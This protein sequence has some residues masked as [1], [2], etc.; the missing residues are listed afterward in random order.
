MSSEPNPAQAVQAALTALYQA[1]DNE[2]RRQ[3][4]LWLRD[5]QKT[6]EAWQVANEL[7]LAQDQPLEGRLFAAQTFRSKV[8][9]DLNQ[10]PSASIPSLRDTLLDALQAYGSGPRVLQTQI[11]LALSALALQMSDWANVIPSIVERFG[12]DP[13]LVPALLEFLTILPE[14]VV[15]NH[16]IP[17][18]E[19]VYHQRV[20]ELLSVHVD[21]VVKVL[22]MYALAKGVTSQIQ[23]GVFH[24]L[25]SWLKSGELSVKTLSKSPLFDLCFQALG[26]DE[27]FDVATDCICDIIHETQEVHENMDIIEQIVPRLGPLHGALQKAIADEDDDQVR[28]ICRILAQAGESY[29]VLVLQHRDTFLP[30]VEAIATCAGYQ[31]LDIVQI[32]F[33]FWYL[34]ASP[35]SKSRRED[36]SLQAFFNIYE[37]LLDTVTQH[38]RFP[39]DMSELTGQEYDDFKSFRHHMG[40][41]LK[42]CCAVLGPQE[43]LTRALNTMQAAMATAGPDG[44]IQWQAVE[45][46]LFSMR[47]MGSRADPSDDTVIP[48]IMDLVPTL[49]P[50]PKLQYAALLVVSRYT[51]WIDRHP[52]RIP[53]ILTYVSGGLSEKDP[54]VAAAA[55]QA[56]NYLCQDC[57]KHL[58]PFLPQLYDFFGTIDE[59]LGPD[60]LVA[61]SVAIGHIIS[62]IQSTSEAIE[63]MQRFTHPILSKLEV[64]ATTPLTRDQLRKVADRIEQLENFL[65]VL[66]SRFW[67]DFPVECAQTCSA[68]YA[69]IDGILDRYGNEYFISERVAGLLRRALLFWGDMLIPTVPGMLTRLAAGFEQTG[70]GGYVWIIGKTIDQFARKADPTLNEAMKAAFERVSQKVGSMVAAAGA[71]RQ[72][73]VVEDYVHT[74]AAVAGNCPK[75]LYLSPVFPE[76]FRIALS[77]LTVL[78]PELVDTA[79]TF[80]REVVG[81][82]ALSI[83]PNNSLPGT[84]L[85]L[86][87]AGAPG[88][89]D[90][91]GSSLEATPQQ[92]AMFANNIRS[93]IQ[94]QGLQLCTLT[95]N[96]LTSDFGDNCLPLAVSVIR[97]LSSLFPAEMMA[98][99]PTATA[100]LPAR[101][102]SATEQQQFVQ[103]YQSAMAGQNIDQIKPILNTLFYAARKAQDRGMSSFKS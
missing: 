1:S 54:D 34:L 90:E 24:C 42:D 80:I 85:T 62:G 53:T 101:S 4:D 82:D 40:D 64:A 17:V 15:N 94:E 95:L 45:A 28:G 46:P 11:S 50:H 22:S 78:R 93:V 61:I 6:P 36:P 18:D 59:Q 38:L 27:L 52:D 67:T 70:F 51:E 68:S 47:A 77:A 25:S 41:T 75:L 98:W 12:S 43:C 26:S 44:S 37:R 92:L 29:H 9:Y 32:T 100:T 35:L 88:T 73:D 48:R 21:D 58:V 87:Y 19:Y 96:G 83:V 84:P 23:N 74:C 39:L 57:S 55:A 31:N 102:V 89:T 14:E 3:A 71:E 16:R 79:L 65:D 91:P 49:P 66:G 33:R 86:V 60:D 30:L 76:A 63:P 10:V 13:V 7:L 103:Q 81:H 2:A 8:V 20:T 69:I 72:Q 97:V 56:L 99:I 5:F